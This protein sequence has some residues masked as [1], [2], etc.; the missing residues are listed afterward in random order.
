[1][2]ES[3]ENQPIDSQ[4]L[5]R[6]IKTHVQEVNINAKQ[7]GLPAAVKEQLQKVGINVVPDYS[8]DAKL[9]L[10]NDPVLVV[11]THPH[12]IND[13]FG[14]L[15]SIPSER[16]DVHVTGH[17]MHLKLGG[18]IA[19]QI[20]PIYNVND[21]PTNNLREMIRRK[22]LGRDR[23]IEA[24][25]KYESAKA[26]VRSLQNAASIVNEGGMVIVF[27]DG[28]QENGAEWMTGVGKLVQDI[29]N[30][31]AKVIFAKTQ[32]GEWRNRARVFSSKT[33]K[34]LGGADLRV[35]FSEPHSISEY[36][37]KSQSKQNITGNLR[38]QYDKFS[39]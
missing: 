33:K 32:G 14:I 22:L 11:A 10:I 25:T 27:P 13:I 17:A 29:H 34:F 7:N 24:L 36:S 5:L 15:S 9:S 20:I 19:N 16:R 6:F 31:D 28:S 4:S 2:S 30:P 3:G 35:G 1:M 39:V 18:E 26:N 23:P 37:G 12:L 38:S 21:Q 8:P